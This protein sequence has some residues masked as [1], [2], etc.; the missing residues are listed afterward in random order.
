[1]RV[2]E[3]T[4]ESKLACAHCGDPCDDKIVTSEGNSF[5]CLGCKTVFEILHENGL[6]AYYRIETKPGLSLKHNK[7]ADYYQ[8]LDNNEIRRKLLNFESPEVSKVRLYIPSI[9]CSS[10]I[11]L[12]E[13]LYKLQQGVIKSEVNFP[14]KEVYIDFN[15]SQVSLRELIELMASLGYEPDINLEQDTSSSKSRR[16]YNRSLIVKIGIAGFC[17]G[18]IMLLSFPEYLGLEKL[19]DDDFSRFFSYINIAFSLPVLIYS[20]SGYYEAAY[21][22]L[23]KKFISIDVPI[24]IGIFTLFSRSIYEIVSQTGPGYLDSL[25]GLVF[26]LLIGKW[27]QN[28]TYESLLFDR[29]YKS[30]FPIGVTRISEENQQ[31][32]MIED[33]KEDDEILIRNGELIPAD[34]ELLSDQALIDNSFVTGESVSI[35]KAKGDYIFAGGRQIGSAIRLKVRKEVS[36]SYLTQLW[37]NEAFVKSKKATRQVMVDRISKYFT[38]IILGIAFSASI[39]WIF[40]DPSKVVN[41]FTAVLIVACP[42]ALALSTPFAVGTAMRIL[43]QLG[44]Y[45]KNGETLEELNKVD[46]VVFDKT[47]TITFNSKNRGKIPRH[48]EANSDHIIKEGDNKARDYNPYGRT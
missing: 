44:C 20:A 45:L 31:S 36:Q 8:F 28:R 38:L 27:F 17:F 16:K 19:L 7:G 13:N 15:P 23:K 46:H 4:I 33:L 43:G 6:D 26:F 22:G 3:K 12:L 10:C 30:Y 5:C 47:G 11:W 9:H 48:R 25:S 39:F 34:S 14:R 37:N 1:M 32:I 21:K 29:S 42:C 35:S 2:E 41:V 24:V 18:N 40:Y